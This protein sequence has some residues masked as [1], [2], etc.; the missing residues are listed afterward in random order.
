MKN[1]KAK[2]YTNLVIIFNDKKRVVYSFISNND[3]TRGFR[4]NVLGLKG[5]AR[6][7]KGWKKHQPVN[8]T[9]WINSY[10]QFHFSFIT[11][12]FEKRSN[13]VKL[14]RTFAKAR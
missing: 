12:A 5:F 1:T 11:L 6:F 10:K 9:N 8:K 7:R 14:S 3:G 4:F 13:P 2:I